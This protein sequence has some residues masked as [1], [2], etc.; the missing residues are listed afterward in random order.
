[1][2]T[3]R[4]AAAGDEIG[5]YTVAREQEYFATLQ[6]REQLL[7]NPRVLFL[8]NFCGPL[9]GVWQVGRSA[10][11]GERKNWRSAFSHAAV[12]RDAILLTEHLE[13]S[14][15]P[16]YAVWEIR[17]RHNGSNLNEVQKNA[18]LKLTGP[19]GVAEIELK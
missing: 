11:N 10:K 13:A 9:A 7:S 15:G 17:I 6:W 5:Y 8:S 19:E 16:A 4:S 1:M 12:F 2:L 14:T 18:G 3:K